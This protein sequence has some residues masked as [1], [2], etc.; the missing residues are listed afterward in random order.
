MSWFTDRHCYLLAVLF[1]GVSMIYSFFLW[2]KGFREDNRINYLLLLAGF[3]MNMTAL[4][5]RGAR[6]GRCPTT[7]LYEAMTFVTWTLLAV[8]LAFGLWTRLRFLG[9]FASPFLFAMGTFALMPG[10]DL[11]NPERSSGI[12]DLHAALSLLSYGAFGLSAVAASMYISQER[13]LKL[14]KMRAVF[15]MMPPMERLEK[16]MS[17][18][19]L[20]GFVLLT[21]G[22]AVSPFLMKERYGVYITD[23]P[24]IAPKLIWS[25]VVWLIYGTLLVLHGRFSQTGRRFAYGSVGS[26]IFVLLTF[27]GVS[28]LSTGHR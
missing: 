7:N 18:L 13:N 3:I 6:F 12:T 17:R 8:Y 5:L 23:N 25:A 1:F 15:S 4:Y 19:L 27:W 26:F 28:L 9:A 21:A 24:E 16:V 11:H 22:L 14:H 20:G 2:R 10:L